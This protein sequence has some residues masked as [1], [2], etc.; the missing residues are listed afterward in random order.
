MKA[1]T[2]ETP[3]S[4]SW[5]YDE[6]L[7]GDIRLPTVEGF[8]VRDNEVTALFERLKSTVDIK[9]WSERE[10]SEWVQTKDCKDD[11]LDRCVLATSL[12]IPLYLV[13]WQHDEEKFRILLVSIENEDR[14]VT[15]DK[16]LFLSC[17]NLAKWLSNLKGIPVSKPF[18]T[19]KRLSSIDECLRL[20]GVPWPG[21]LDG[22]LL[23]PKTS[24]ISV[25]FELRRTRVYSVRKHNLNDYFHKDY[26]GWEALDI[27][28]NQLS[29]P[30][31][32][33]TWSSKETL[34]KIQKLHKITKTGLDYEKIEFVEKTEIVP[35]FRQFM[36]A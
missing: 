33:L 23:N 35:F 19:P 4:R 18:V 25:L 8:S 7:E 5:I 10:V 36:K 12:E 29:I 32:I 28:R 1:L 27:L 22:F 14:I 21:N 17:E 13:L 15:K 3:E 11:W 20:Y 31:Y 2:R 24:E 16:K 6:L 30:L 34:V 26:H 9:K